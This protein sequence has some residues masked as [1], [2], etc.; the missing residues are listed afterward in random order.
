MHNVYFDHVIGYVLPASR[1]QSLRRL[2][3]R[4][5]STAPNNSKYTSAYLPH[6]PFSPNV[7]A[8][9]SALCHVHL[10]G[11]I[12]NV[13]VGLVVLEHRYLIFMR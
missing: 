12:A 4:A 7:I 9:Y 2:A 3:I 11:N 5:T 13:A 8:L 10:F 6:R 1:K